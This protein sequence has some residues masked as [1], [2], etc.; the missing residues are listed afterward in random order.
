VGWGLG[1]VC[2]CVQAYTY[3][4]H[5]YSHEHACINPPHTPTYPRTYFHCGKKWRPP[6]N[7]HFFNI[8]AVLFSTI[9][10]VAFTLHQFQELWPEKSCP[11]C[12]K[13]VMITSINR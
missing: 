9:F 5:T 1:H 3:S 8:P 7:H 10:Q 12:T 2:V 11:Q 13:D 6:L 4:L